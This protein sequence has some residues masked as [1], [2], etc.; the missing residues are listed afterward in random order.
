MPKKDVRKTSGKLENF[1]LLYGISLKVCIVRRTLLYENNILLIKS[2]GYKSD[3]EKTFTHKHTHI[4]WA[5]FRSRAGSRAVFFFQQLKIVISRRKIVYLYVKIANSFICKKRVIFRALVKLN[6][7][8]RN[9]TLIITRKMI[10]IPVEIMSLS[11]ADRF[12]SSLM[13]LTMTKRKRMGS[14]GCRRGEQTK[15]PFSCIKYFFIWPCVLRENT[16]AISRRCVLRDNEERKME[17]ERKRILEEETEWYSD[18]MWVCMCVRGRMQ[19][20]ESNR[21]DER[22]GKRDNLGWWFF[23][24]F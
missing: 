18:E 19:M 24:F 11:T 1:R 2:L 7:A 16:C 22:K 14:G 6:F 12:F 8:D 17:R 21:K 9:W 4:R 15:Q 23:T 10:L 5:H 3:R 20:N 13:F